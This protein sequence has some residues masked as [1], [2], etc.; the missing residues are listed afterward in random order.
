ARG[1]GAGVA[2]GR[3]PRAPSRTRRATLTAPGAPRV[4]PAGQP[5]VCAAAGFGVRGG[6][7]G[8]P[9]CRVGATATLDAPVK[10]TP[11]QANLHPWSQ[12]RRRSALIPSRCLPAYLARIQRISRF[13]AWWSTAS[14]IA[15]DT[16]CRK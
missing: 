13:H 10:A 14:N 9:R 12:K 6:G 2:A 7:R 4:F 16:P 11:L 15:L 8:L 3:L 1:R 5:L